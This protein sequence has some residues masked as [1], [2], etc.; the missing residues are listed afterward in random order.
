VLGSE[1]TV[2][3]KTTDRGITGGNLYS[4]YLLSKI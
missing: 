3:T 4:T 2:D 1:W